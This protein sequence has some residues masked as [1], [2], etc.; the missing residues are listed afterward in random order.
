MSTDNALVIQKSKRFTLLIDPE[1]QGVT[2]LKSQ[3]E[4]PGNLYVLKQTDQNFKK[5]MEMAIE[6][7]KV[8]IVEGITQHV[9]MNLQS[10]MKKQISKYSG[11]RM[12]NFCRKQYKYDKNFDLYVVSTAARP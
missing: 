7:G 9:N 2:F 1:M 6:I 8:V 11:S 5:M 10:I 3:F 12:M 4:G